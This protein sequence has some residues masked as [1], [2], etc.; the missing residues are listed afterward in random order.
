MSKTWSFDKKFVYLENL[1][2]NILNKVEKFS[3]IGQ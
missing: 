2:K 1:R 3:R